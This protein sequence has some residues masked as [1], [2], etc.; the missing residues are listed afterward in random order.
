M[1]AVTPASPA[2]PRAAPRPPTY[3]RDRAL[4]SITTAESHLRKIEEQA[5]ERA[6]ALDLASNDVIVARAQELMADSGRTLNV[7][8]AV[9][10]A[11]AEAGLQ[12]PRKATDAD[13]GARAY[14]LA[15]ES[16]GKLITVAAVDQAR[17]EAS[18]GKLTQLTGPFDNVKAI[19]EKLDT[20][21]DTAMETQLLDMA[22]KAIAE[23]H[24][25]LKDGLPLDAGERALDAREALFAVEKLRIDEPHLAKRLLKEAAGP[26]RA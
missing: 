5:R 16:G 3:D 17:A 8:F 20:G 6:R 12:A 13:I 21:I 18:A 19:A 11:R 24:R 15:A 7:V 22:R 26:F 23:A 4:A 2:T 9:D 10:Q 25:K 14:E 1:P